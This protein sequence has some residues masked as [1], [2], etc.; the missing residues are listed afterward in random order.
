M[1]EPPATAR[2]AEQ[3]SRW[4]VLAIVGVVKEEDERVSRVQLQ[5]SGG[6]LNIVT[7]TRHF[8]LMTALM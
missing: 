7:K 2:Q 6:G 1:G 8:C 5:G 3:L 4:E